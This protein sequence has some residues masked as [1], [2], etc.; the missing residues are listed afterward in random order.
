MIKKAEFV[1]SNTDLRKCPEP[2]R[3]EYAFIG[4]SNVG[5][6]SLINM[7]TGQKSLA[8]TSVRP[9]KTQLVNHFNID[10][11]WYLVDLPG[12]GYARASKTAKYKFQ[13]LISDYIL[14]RENLY[15][16]FVLVDSRHELQKIDSEFMMWLGENAIPFAIIF[17][18]ADKLG[19]TNLDK[20]ISAYKKQL[21]EVWDELP[22]LLIS[23]AESG[24][25]K[26]EILE[27]IYSINNQ[28]QAEN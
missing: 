15:C 26:K 18:K 28:E 3:P 13:K 11:S 8:K 9:G 25:G 24:T 12:Y 14:K 19:K 5:K 16:L 4:R 20:N 10:D 1:I 22:P 23:S 27:F 17:T 7:I 2:D 6:S 21:K